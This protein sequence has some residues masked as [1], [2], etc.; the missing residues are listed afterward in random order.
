MSMWKKSIIG[1]EVVDDPGLGTAHHHFPAKSTR[2]FTSPRRYV[3]SR[4]PL[5][6]KTSCIA[7]QSRMQIPK[8]PFA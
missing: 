6:N 4:V 1:D 3:D 7:K 5:Y 2:H 8:N